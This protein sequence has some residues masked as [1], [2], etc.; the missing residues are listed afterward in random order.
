MTVA[1]RR[2][3]T[4]TIV[5]PDR[6]QLVL[7]AVA[8]NPRAGATT[9]RPS[10]AWRKAAQTGISDQRPYLAIQASLAAPRCIPQQQRL[11]VDAC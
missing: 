7:D 4:S 6:R 2:D 8:I 1:I 5:S 11:S 10:A 3:T 9:G